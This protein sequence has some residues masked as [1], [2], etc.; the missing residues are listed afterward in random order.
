MNDLDNLRRELKRNTNKDK[1][2]NYR[3]YFKNSKDDLFLGISV[4]IL[5][6]IAKEFYHLR[7]RDI[8]VLMKSKVH[9]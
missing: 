6:K 8:L 2:V 3:K 4:P 7:T 1:A 5:R 9:V